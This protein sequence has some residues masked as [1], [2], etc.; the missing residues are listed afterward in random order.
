MYI[1]IGSYIIYYNMGYNTAD[2]K[3]FSFQMS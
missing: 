2:A 1:Y 3:L